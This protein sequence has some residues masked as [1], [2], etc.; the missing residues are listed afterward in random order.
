MATLKEYN[1]V[2]LIK[3]IHYLEV[4]YLNIYIYIYIE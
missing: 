1:K 2:G 3:Y 4:Y